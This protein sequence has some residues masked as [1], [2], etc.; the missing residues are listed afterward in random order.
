MMFG[1]ILA[2]LAL[3]QFDHRVERTLARSV[4]VGEEKRRVR[5]RLEHEVMRAG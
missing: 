3:C 5:L 2:V 1:P 4:M